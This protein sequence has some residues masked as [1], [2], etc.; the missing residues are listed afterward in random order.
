MDTIKME[1]KPAA[2]LVQINF[3]NKAIPKHFSKK[4]P[5]TELF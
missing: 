5:L 2:T 3:E 1:I 4:V